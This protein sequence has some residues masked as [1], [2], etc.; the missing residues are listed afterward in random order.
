MKQKHFIFSLCAL[1]ATAMVGIAQTAKNYAL[2]QPLLERVYS[3]SAGS[4]LQASHWVGS[5]L[6]SRDGETRYVWSLNADGSGRIYTFKNFMGKLK[7]DHAY[8]VYWYYEPFTQMA[9]I[10]TERKII[11][12]NDVV[13]PYFFTLKSYESDYWIKAKF[14]WV[15]TWTETNTGKNYLSKTSVKFVEAISSWKDP[16]KGDKCPIFPNLKNNRFSIFIFST[17]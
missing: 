7:F 14:F 16:Q 17:I 12:R 15:A 4:H 8:D 2:Q 3:W 11:C 6:I 10:K 9:N 13:Y 1:L 5:W